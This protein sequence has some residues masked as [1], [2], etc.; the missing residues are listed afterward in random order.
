MR[1]SV[2]VSLGTASEIGGPCTPRKP[3]FL[4]GTAFVLAAMGPLGAPLTPSS[5]RPKIPMSISVVP[6][7]GVVALV[8]CGNSDIEGGIDV[9]NPAVD[10]LVN[11][12]LY[13]SFCRSA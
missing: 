8:T 10:V 12:F 13:E 4:L 2:I 7:V 1:R 3:K 5:I 11:L 6:A 9:A